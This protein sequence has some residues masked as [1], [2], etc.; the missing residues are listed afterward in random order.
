MRRLICAA[1]FIC[2]LNAFSFAQDCESSFK[3]I[4]KNFEGGFYKGQ[5]VT[6]TIK[7]TTKKYEV[8]SNEKGE[9]VFNLPCNTTCL[10][11][12][13]NYTRTREVQTPGFK[14]GQTMTA[15]T[16]EPDAIA[17]EKEFAM[18]DSEKAGVDKVISSL[19]DTTYIKG[20]DMPAPA[21]PEN[22]T[23]ATISIVDLDAKPLSGE[24]VSI[25][26]IKRGKTFK[27]T[28]NSAGKTTVYLPK[29][30]NYSINFKF[31]KNYYTFEVAYSQGTGHADI[32]LGYLGTKE[33]LRRKKLEAERLAAEEKRLAEEKKRME[34]AARIA[35]LSAEEYHKRELADYKKK[36][37]TGA[38]GVV[39]RVLNRNKW[40]KKLIVCDITG[41]MSPY[42]NELALW[43]TLR[44]AVEKD[45]QFVFFND[46]DNKSTAD[47]K[48]GE[49][50]GIYY[51]DGMDADGLDKFMSMVASKGSGGDCPENNMEALIQ[52]V[53]QAKP[54]KDLI[55]IA[56][57][58]APVKDISL[59]KKFTKPVHVILCGAT[60]DI[61]PDYLQ[62]AW[63]TGGSVHTIE[64]DITKIATMAEGQEIS[65]G[66]ARYKIMGGEFI[67]VI[68]S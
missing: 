36:H 56:D 57:N 19:K 54:H 6:A 46:G 28:T 40:T 63:K 49:T 21:N 5:T 11:T 16:Y 12:A 3:I 2:V 55:M 15:F 53:K 50:G 44:F 23:P 29:G 22:F 62:I 26:G 61:H 33:I 45:M 67:K 31:H 32:S 64:E 25:T 4:L 51:A 7:G 66:G 41:S 47:K 59:L 9:A 42:T 58:Y 27:A 8:I 35:K 1:C 24:V 52:A 18:N 38:D 14:G 37:K 30:D 17:K 48:I 65:I 43:Y 34:E 68:K 10:V 20:S 13:S 39:S 60:S